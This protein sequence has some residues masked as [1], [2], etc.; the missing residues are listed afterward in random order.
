MKKVEL[1]A[2]AGSYSALIS[3]VNAGC[4][5]VYLGGKNF[6][7]RAYA[8]NFDYEEL[9]KALE[10]CHL[11]DVKV[12]VTL[13]TL[14]LNEEMKEFAEYVDFLYSIG[15]DAV[16]VQDLGVLKFL[17]ENYPNLSVHAST[18]MTIHN[19]E[20]V[21][22]L[23]ERGVSRVILSRELTLEEIRHI[24]SNS[25]ID[26][27]VFVHGA[28]CVSYSGQCFMSSLIGGRSG[29]RGRC[30]QPCR[31][32]YSLV[33]KRGSILR[34][35]LHLL[36]MVDLCTIEHIPLL[37]EA[38]VSSFKIEGRMKSPEYVASVV[39]AYREAIDSYYDGKTFDTIKAMEEMAKVFNR[40]FSSGYLFEKKP[41]VMSYITPKNIGVP[42][43]EVIKTKGR[44]VKVRLLQDIRKGDGISD[45]KGEKGHRIQEII[46]NGK[47]V[48]MAFKGE[49]VALY[50]DF[51]PK[52]K[53]ILN[54][55]YDHFLNESLKNLQERKVP[56]KIYAEFKKGRPFVVRVEDGIFF[57]E[58]N[59]ESIPELAKKVSIEEDFLKNKLSQIGDTPFYPEKIVVNLDKGLFMPVKD[60][61][62]TRR[63]AID[64]LKFKKLAFYQREK[65]QKEVNLPEGEEKNENPV[66]TFYTDKL[67]HLE[68][69]VS[70]GIQYIYFDYKLNESILKQAVKLLRGK[71]TVLVAA[72]P[73]ILRE[74]MKD[75]KRQL[76]LL[77]ELDIRNILVSNLGLYHI[78]KNKDFRLFIDYPLNVFNSL[79]VECFNAYAVTLSYEL[80]L[81]QMKDI[82]KRSD[83]KFEAVIYGRLPLMTTEYCPIRN[84]LGCD[85]AKCEKGYYF[86]KDRK[87]KLMP[88]KNNGFCRIQILNGDVLFMANH[89]EEL[90]KSGLSFLRINDTI[91]DDEEIERILQ[92]H[93]K[94]LEGEKIEIPEGNYTKGHFYRGV[95]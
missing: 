37:I 65:L 83:I 6:G 80:T 90:K 71:D 74:E 17:R 55:T 93:V 4:D 9:K 16:I 26:I 2:P 94:A 18:Q 30:A 89:M 68:I 24:A 25:P 62:E 73:S 48:D 34:E 51:Y 21:Q 82:A 77:R 75:M 86:L 13:N 92:I 36:S 46:K 95:L 76:Q 50:L 29:N 60:I 3:A 61:K 84:V 67:N 49:V 59:S 70:L 66:L 53:E 44:E 78:L 56:V 81:E 72:F 20:G 31:L 79:A 11:R 58:A 64:E 27:E 28:M 38:G 63:K 40:G 8:P 7:A 54:K 41:S 32:K 10:F 69:A 19:L 22:E 35:N 14:I 52:E 5:A 45:S 87:G 23:A 43:A 42:V 91:E 12:Y 47:K 85:R 57:G 1:L 88:I 39:R 33:D 15:V